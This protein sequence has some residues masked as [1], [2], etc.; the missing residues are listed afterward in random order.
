MHLALLA[1]H[2]EA[3]PIVA[4]WY[5]DDSGHKIA[6]NSLE[7]TCARIKGKLNK[8]HP[9]LH[10]LA[11]I[12]ERPVGVAQWKKFEMPEYPNKEHWLGSVFVAPEYRGGKIGEA[13]AKKVASIAQTNGAK[14]IYLSTERLD[15]GLYLKAGWTPYERT[16]SRGDDVL[17]MIKKL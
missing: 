7:A 12:D 10:V 3:V 5:F 4:K 13:L 9:P 8:T 6:G 1:D 16:I 17:V 14:E 11:L 2:L 15:G